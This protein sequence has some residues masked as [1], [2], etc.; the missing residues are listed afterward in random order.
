MA[1]SV[2]LTWHVYHV[3]RYHEIGVCVCV[4]MKKV[5]KKGQAY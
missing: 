3:L 5:A 1:T 4:K 2:V